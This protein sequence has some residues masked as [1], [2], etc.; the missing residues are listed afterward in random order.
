[1]LSNFVSV[2][3]PDGDLIICRLRG[4]LRRQGAVLAGDKVVYRQVDGD[5]LVEK[6]L[7]R[8]SRL[9]RPPVANVDQ[10]VVVFT[11]REPELNLSLLDRLLVLVA[12]QR[13]QALLVLNKVDLLRPDEAES[14]L[15]VYRDIGYRALAVSA[16]LGTGLDR[17]AQE[18][19][20]RISV[21]AGASGVGK[22]RLLSA[23][24]PG[25]ELL[26]GELSPKGGRGRHTTRWVEMI[27]L[28]DGGMVADAPGFTRLDLDRIPSRSLPDCFPEMAKL[29]GS[30][31]FNDCLH[32]HEPG[33]AIK[34]AVREGRIARHRYDHYLSFLGE[35]RE[36]E[37]RRYQ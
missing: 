25:K 15:G 21:F 17:L 5:G 10:V 16:I 33:C 35:I 4:R 24:V 12:Y 31:Q 22:S 11:L 6:V 2:L 27:L 32:H 1:M 20:H 23:L 9:V 3:S 7:P 14:L 29:A 30:C 19:R 13:L 18:L 28:P 26:T 37:E 36:F 34:E 8:R